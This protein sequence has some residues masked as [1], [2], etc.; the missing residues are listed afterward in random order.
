[1][2]A[3]GRT[4]KLQWPM[5]SSCCAVMPTLAT[6]A[7]YIIEWLRLNNVLFSPTLPI[8]LPALP[9]LGRRRLCLLQKCIRTH[10]LSGIGWRKPH[11]QITVRRFERPPPKRFNE[12]S[13]HTNVARPLSSSFLASNRKNS[14]SS[15]KKS[16][17][18]AE[19]RQLLAHSSQL[20]QVAS[21]PSSQSRPKRW[22]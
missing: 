10:A 14:T 13:H 4:P 1:M 2:T 8:F 11:A 18:F 21:P 15:Q 19:S 20:F 16:W 22:N 6:N 5:P 7:S 17:T 3:I 9:F 12:T